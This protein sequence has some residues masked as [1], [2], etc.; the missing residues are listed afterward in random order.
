MVNLKMKKFKILVLFFGIISVLALVNR[1]ESQMLNP[2]IDRAD[3]PFCY[4]SQ[5]TDV[6]GVMDGREGTLVSPEGYLYTGYGEMMFFTGNPPEPVSQR[7]KTLYRGYLP[8]IQYDYKKDDILYKFSM[9]AATQDAKP[10]S[11]L[12]NFIRVKISNQAAGKR[13]AFFSAA[14]RYQNDANTDWGVAD[15]RFGR[16]AAAKFPGQYEQTGAEFTQDWEY[17]FSDDV[18]LRDG[19]V[20]YLF[21]ATVEHERFMTFKTGYNEA[22]QIAPMKLYVLPT[23]PVGIVTFRLLM[24]PGES[25]ILDFKMPYE[26]LTE[27]SE[28][29]NQLRAAT[30]DDYLQKT[31]EFWQQIFSRGIEI[32]VPEEKVVNTFKANLIYDL[33]ARDKVDS[34]YIQKVNE[35]QYDAFWLRDA[36]FV[37]R[38][39]DV[40]G[41]HDIARQCLDFFPRWQRDDGNFV[42]QG[43]QYDGW[44]QTLWAYGEHF[45]ISGDQAF[46]EKV[47]PA[48][49]R[50]V[51]WLQ[52]AR[53]NDPLHLI[54]VTTPGDNENITGHVTGHNFWALIG[55]KN[56]IALANGLGKSEEAQQFQ[57]EYDDLLFCL[58]DRLREV[59][60]KTD[61]YI[62]PGLDTLGGQDWGNMMAI[63]P[64]IIFQP[65]D[66]M[67]TATLQTTR[68]KYQEGIMT[69]GDGRYLHHY[70]TMKNTESE[71]I[72]GEQEIALQEFYAMLAHTSATHAGFEFSI[73]PWGT[74]DFGMNLSPHGWFSANFRTLMRNMMIREQEGNLHLLSLISPEWIQ[75]GKSILVKRAAT[76]FGEVNFDLKFSSGKATL[77]LGN[78][79]RTAPEKLILHLPW[80][81]DVQAVRSC[82]QMLTV[83]KNKVE[84]PLTATR[85]EIQYTPRKDVFAYS[86]Q[87]AV[88][89]YQNEYRQRYEK[90]LKNGE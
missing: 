13:V 30:F 65:F 20:M 61:G 29:V 21:P 46:A 63:Y 8:V 69:Y 81:W 43:G 72:R 26:P 15:N 18:L 58:R 89:D 57:R 47:F 12:I 40:S 55:L 62:P 67:V 75:D 70:L 51:G 36:A 38:M 52:Q 79:F 6:I 54:P 71:L 90:F 39:Y 53:E 56:V 2:E 73:L 68:S 45:K 59:T 27:A 4:F 41:Y 84:L 16:P 42:S 25:R 44:G 17:E 78:K 19:T 22:Q 77:I 60:A 33:I 76:D 9:F 85:V 66:P 1:A 24:K 35:F 31:A 10:E 5:P 74:R 32:S 82:E 80:F 7:V 83:S 34:F 3:E 11:P 50:A 87:K 64:E 86:Y 48:M 28:I 37:A 14:I 88:L 23:T 49:K